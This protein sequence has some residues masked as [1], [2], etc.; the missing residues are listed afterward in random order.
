MA[1][2]FNSFGAPL[3]EQPKPKKQGILSSL[4][5][6]IQSAFNER[7]DT[8]STEIVRAQGGEIS[9]QRAALRTGGQAAGFLFDIP[10]E[11]A[12]A[13]APEP[14]KEVAKTTLEKIAGTDIA[15]GLANKYN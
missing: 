8:A 14:V 10:F 2:D 12:K 1:F 7:V 6:G 5:S 9:P 3:T 13:V 4:T 15:Q 11:A